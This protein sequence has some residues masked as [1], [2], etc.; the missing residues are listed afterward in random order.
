MSEP[1]SEGWRELQTSSRRQCPKLFYQFSTTC[2]SLTLLVTDL[3]SIWET[4]LDSYDIKAT[5]ARQHTTIDPSASARQFEVLLSKLRHSLS[6]GDN[7]ITRGSEKSSQTLHLRTTIDLPHPLKPLDW[8][9]TLEPQTSSELAERILRPSLHEVAVSQSKINSLLSIVREKDHVISKLLDRIGNSAVDLSLVFPGIAGLASRKGSHVSVADAKKRVP[10]MAEFDEEGW[11]K[12][13][14]NDDGYEGADRTGLSKLVRGCEKCFV[15]SKS[16]HDN[17]VK[18][19]PTTTA[20]LRGVKDGAQRKSPPMTSAKMKSR[21]DNESTDDEF[22]RQPTPPHLKSTSP[23]AKRVTRPA[24]TTDDEETQDEESTLPKS[25]KPSKIGGL[26]RRG[27]TKAFGASKGP[28]KASPPVKRTASPVRR[29]SPASS[30]PATAT[31]TATASEDENEDVDLDDEDIR[32]PSRR[33][34]KSPQPAQKHKPRGANKKGATTRSPS[35]T[36]SPSLSPSPLPTRSHPKHSSPASLPRGKKEDHE[37]ETETETETEDE[38]EGENKDKANDRDQ[39]TSTYTSGSAEHKPKSFKLPT[40]ATARPSHRLG[41]LGARKTVTTPE[42][43]PDPATASAS[44]SASDE[45]PPPSSQRDETQTV[46]K[47]GIRKLGALRKRKQPHGDET[48][49]PPMT[50]PDADADAD[51]DSDPRGSEPPKHAGPSRSI[52]ESRTKRRASSAEPSPPKETAE[53][54][55]SRRRMQ[56]KRTIEAGVVGKKKRR[57]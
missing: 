37:G 7:T 8:T 1:G 50:R 17:W 44:A 14:A 28:A 55:A 33:G 25:P 11:I 39:P 56:L 3:I 19:L 27:A 21:P 9:F 22:E 24:V 52:S 13:F 26:G 51:A 53:E 45:E 41:R 15:H 47:A 48:S 43:T 20:M 49:S 46:R 31:A 30:E 42:P 16:E 18:D 4:N 54:A 57:F 23:T 40:P 12:Q 5:A 6:D 34:T 35:A 36:P 2:E 32:L 29:A 38:D 10:G